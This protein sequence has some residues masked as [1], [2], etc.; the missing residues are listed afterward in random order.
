MTSLVVI[1]CVVPVQCNTV[2][3]SGVF[4]RPWADETPSHSTPAEQN[5][6]AASDPVSGSEQVRPASKTESSIWSVLP[7][8]Q[9][10]F[11]SGSDPVASSEKVCAR[12]TVEP[13]VCL[14]FCKEDGIEQKDV[15]FLI[16][17][18]SV[19]DCKLARSMV[20]GSTKMLCVIGGIPQGSMA[21]LE[22][23][24]LRM[25]WLFCKFSSACFPH[26]DLDSVGCRST[27]HGT[28]RS[29][30]VFP[31]SIASAG[32]H[33]LLSCA[34]ALTEHSSVQCRCALMC[35]GVFCCCP[36]HRSCWTCCHRVAAALCTD[37]AGHA[38][39]ARGHPRTAAQRGF[40]ALCGGCQQHGWAE[41][42]GAHEGKAGVCG[43]KDEGRLRRLKGRAH[44][45]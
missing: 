37:F 24:F 45:G 41:D 18:R 26:A 27:R 43:R 21:V 39:T 17:G 22:A 4:G 38:D 9:S 32:G 6:S 28:R 14:V 16:S 20:L 42:G 5:S 1:H 30:V 12:K 33:Y 15:P 29:T 35:T 8:R 7:C 10:L 36:A 3:G 25:L 34:F 19:R 2:Q 23:L 11:S 40:A 31:L 13:L 44:R